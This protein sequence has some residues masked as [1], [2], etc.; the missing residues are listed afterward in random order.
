MR[1]KIAILGT[2]I[3]LSSASF[4]LNEAAIIGQATKNPIKKE[5]NLSSSNLSI[6]ERIKELEKNYGTECAPEELAYAKTYLEV[7][8]GL[9]LAGKTVKVS[10]FERYKLLK[11]ADLKLKLAEAKINSDLDK[12]GVPCYLEVIK[13][14]DPYKPDIA[15]KNESNKKENIKPSAKV[16]KEKKKAS[17]KSS[18]PKPL[19][20][21]A[22]VH[23]EFNK[24]NIKKEYLPYL[25]V[26]V[27]YLKRH[28]ELKIKIVGYTDSIGSKAYNDKLAL[29]RAKSVKQYL[30]KRGISPDRIK[31]E[32][33]GKDKYLFDN[34]TALN[35][36]TNRRAEFFIMNVE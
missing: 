6:E 32:G 23:F 5:G 12:D 2:I 17:V 8:K 15:L 30:V 11:Y 22:R 21:Q 36:F 10:K 18:M 14:T 20:L 3:A 26:I 27:R 35:R 9:K 4:G 24:A 25:N 13:G 34:K 1:H 28:P 29:K 31:I 7:A 16:L 33:I 19:K